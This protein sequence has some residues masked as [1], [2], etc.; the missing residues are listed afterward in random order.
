MSGGPS[1]MKPRFS[2][3]PPVDAYGD[4]GFR[5]EGQRF[6]GSIIV[7]PRGLYPWSAAALGDVTAASLAVLADAASTVDFLLIGSGEAF[8]RLPAQAQRH[9]ESRGLFPDMMATPAACRTYNM[10]LAEN[11]RVAAALIA[12]P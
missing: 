4:G 10:M 5:L 6:D 7:T 1:G 2:G 9:L 12:V 3:Q 8:A 11:R